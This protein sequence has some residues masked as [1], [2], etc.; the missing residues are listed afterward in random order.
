MPVH[1]RARRCAFLSI[2]GNVFAALFAA[3]GLVG[4]VGAA[5]MN[6]VVGP[7][8]TATKVTRQNVVENDLLMNA[9]VIVMDA[10]MRPQQG[11]ADGDGYIEPVPF[12]PA[13][14]T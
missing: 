11:D 13:R 12:I 9:R 5:V 8:T 14:P 2:K 4:V 10:A 7:A 3:V 1:I 6:V